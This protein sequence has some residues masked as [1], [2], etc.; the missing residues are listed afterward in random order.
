M[1]DWILDNLVE[2]QRT[3]RGVIAKLK[4]LGLV[5]KAPTKRSAK[6]RAA[7][8]QPGD[9]GENSKEASGTLYYCTL[10]SDHMCFLQHASPDSKVLSY[11]RIVHLALAFSQEEGAR[12]NQ[13]EAEGR[14]GSAAT[15][16]SDAE[17]AGTERR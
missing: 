13:V 6:Q 2:Q 5:F 16:E 14:P 17:T 7:A 11:F 4:Q 15:Q 3:R 8:T 9:L 10:N 1:I 12:Q